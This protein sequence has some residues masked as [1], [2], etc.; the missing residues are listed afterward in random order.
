[1]KG[2]IL[3]VAIA[4]S[5]LSGCAGRRGAEPAA[6][7]VR[8]VCAAGPL[9]P[10]CFRAASERCGRAGYDLF[11]SQGRRAT[12]ADARHRVLEARCRH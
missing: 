3:A 1:M 4:L 2:S 5:M 7:Q 6:A 10:S 8:I 11:D 12:V 9:E